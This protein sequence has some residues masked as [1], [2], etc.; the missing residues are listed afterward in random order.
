ML[1]LTVTSRNRELLIRIFKMV[2][3]DPEY[4]DVHMLKLDA[5]G[6]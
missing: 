6:R 2:E 3:K 4:S 1:K 5:F